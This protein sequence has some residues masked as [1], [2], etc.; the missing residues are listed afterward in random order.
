[1]KKYNQF[2]LKKFSHLFGEKFKKFNFKSIK[3]N[4]KKDADSLIS[5]LSKSEKYQLII[6]KINQFYK[7]EQK[8]NNQKATKNYK[9]ILNKISYSEKYLKNIFYLKLNIKN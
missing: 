6:K 3:P 5:R 9:S 1:M 2:F 4:F 7:E 8:I